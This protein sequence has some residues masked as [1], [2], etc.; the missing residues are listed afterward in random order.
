[1]SKKPKPAVSVRIEFTVIDEDGG[2]ITQISRLISLDEIKNSRVP[3]L[4]M[5]AEEEARKFNDHII[6]MGFI[7]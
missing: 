6:M 1:M 2:E 7:D 5:K 4:S 3:V